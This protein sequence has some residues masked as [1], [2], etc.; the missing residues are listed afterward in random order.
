MNNSRRIIGFIEVRVRD[1]HG[2]L[3]PCL[4][5]TWQIF[6]WNYADWLQ[7]KTFS[8]LSRPIQT[9][10]STTVYMK[11][12]RFKIDWIWCFG[13]SSEIEIY[14]LSCR[15]CLENPLLSP[16]FTKNTEPAPWWHCYG[17]PSS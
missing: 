16:D 7:A 10:Q 14:T 5:L 2:G 6:K 12:L 15:Y 13:G 3:Y 4:V 11:G 1:L 9:P 17:I 8:E